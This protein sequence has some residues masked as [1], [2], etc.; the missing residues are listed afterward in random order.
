[1]KRAVIVG[2]GL[3]GLATAVRLSALGWQVTV[4]EAGLSF[5]GKMNSWR[6]KGFHFDTGPSLIT[7]PWVFADLFKAAGARME[8]Y[9]EL[10]PI[11]PLSEYFFADGTR[12]SYSSVLSQWIPTLQRVAPDDV[13][14]FFRFMQ[15]GARLYELS[16][17]TFLRRTPFERPGPGDLG[18]LRHFPLRHGWGNYHKTVE[19]HF[20]SPY[21]R[22]LFDR[23]P[24]YVGSSPYRSPATLAVIPYIEYVF[25]GYGVRGGLYRI[26]EALLELARKLAVTLCPNSRVSAI[27]HEGRKVT[28]VELES[29]EAIPADIVVMNGDASGTAKLLGNAAAPVRER[30]MSGLVFLFG[31]RR[32]LPGIQQHSIYFSSDYKAEFSQIFDEGR[33]PDDPTVYV[34]CPSR[35]DRSLVP[36]DGET[37]FVMANAPSSGEEWTESRILDARQRVLARL[38][39][40]GFPDIE[41]DVVVSDTW[42]PSRIARQYGMPGGSIYGDASHGWRST[43]L[44][45]PNRDRHYQGLY[46]VGGSTHPG[47]GTPTVLLS[48]EIACRLIAAR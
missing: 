6:E 16:K 12:F 31:L 24:T 23:Y 27:R 11:N 2:G 45:P 10:L 5:G 33:F 17:H 38:R 20:R 14:G 34:N 42:T 47:G 43:F 21:L 44:R 46:F 19:A 26:V 9:I 36:G 1:M 29:G 40:G 13:D 32:Q 25:G 37:L 30:S 48:A 35:R 4:C 15:L 3:G 41:S 8:D 22:Q 28:G 7:M 39:K 18:T